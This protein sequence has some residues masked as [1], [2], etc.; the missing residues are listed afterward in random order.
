MIM[1][2]SCRGI[3]RSSRTR[4]EKRSTIFTR[5]RLL[6]RRRCMP[7][8]NGNSNCER[9]GGALVGWCCEIVVGSRESIFSELCSNGIRFVRWKL[10]ARRSFLLRDDSFCRRFAN[11]WVNL[12][13]ERTKEKSIIKYPLI[14]SIFI[15]IFQILAFK[16]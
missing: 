12:I 2:A 14:S 4:R 15:F 1:R 16:F 11:A 7:I 9:E 13:F 10:C 5:F 3:R 6:F 8:G